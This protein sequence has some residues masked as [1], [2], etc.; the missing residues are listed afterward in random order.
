MV[1][2]LQ[3]KEMQVVLAAWVL[4][5]ILLVVAVAPVL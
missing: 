1:R 2:E 5:Y 3:V 4:N